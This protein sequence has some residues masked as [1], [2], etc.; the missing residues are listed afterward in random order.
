V[1]LD[2]PIC[3]S[4]PVARKRKA[5]MHTTI[6]VGKLIETSRAKQERHSLS[7]K[8]YYPYERIFTLEEVL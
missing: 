4:A 1:E 8:T 5:T 3:A 7:T 6:L 2:P